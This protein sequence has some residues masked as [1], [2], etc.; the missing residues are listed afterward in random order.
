MNGRRLAQ[1]HV[2]QPQEA[3]PGRLLEARTAWRGALQSDSPWSNHSK[4]CQV[5]RTVNLK[6]AIYTPEL[7]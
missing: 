1:W 6:Y 5:W 3:A 4:I 7:L 2:L